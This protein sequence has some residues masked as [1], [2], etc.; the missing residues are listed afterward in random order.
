MEITDNCNS[1]I[2]T[3]YYRTQ[4]H[5]ITFFK[6]IKP[7]TSLLQPR[8]APFLSHTK[9]EHIFIA[10]FL[11]IHFNIVLSPTP[12]SLC[13]FASRF[14]TTI[15]KTL[16]LPHI[17]STCPTH[18]VSFNFITL[19][20][21]G[22]VATVPYYTD[23]ASGLSFSF[24]LSLRAKYSLLTPISQTSTLS[25]ILNAVRKKLNKKEPVL[26]FNTSSPL[27]NSGQVAN[28]YNNTG[29]FFFRKSLLLVR[30]H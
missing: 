30:P 21:G 29:R 11:K 3:E 4:K 19:T 26:M 16:D 24:S 25:P 8:L 5:R 15:F 10:Y 17:R 28:Q 7:D 20:F 13:F 2:C 23:F 6:C 14:Q 1:A 18:L 22:V 9:I 27:R 12:T